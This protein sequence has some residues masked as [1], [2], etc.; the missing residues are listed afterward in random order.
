MKVALPAH[1]VA[2]MDA[3][4]D[5]VRY[6][7]RSEFVTDAVAN[8]ISELE[9]GIDERLKA[10]A[11]DQLRAPFAVA[12]KEQDHE[13]DYSKFHHA[14]LGTEPAAL[15]NLLKAATRSPG[16]AVLSDRAAAGG[17][18]SAVS[19]AIEAPA[20]D[21]PLA[22]ELYPQ[23]A[24]PT[25]GMHNRDWPTLWAASELGRASFGGAV[26]FKP[27]VESL[28]ER[29][30]ELAA[31][32]DPREFD[33]SGLPSNR[34]K[35]ERS[36]GRFQSFFVGDAPGNGPLFDLRLAAPAGTDSVLLTPPG[37]QLL[38]DLAGLEPRR[39]GVVRPEWRHAFLTHLAAWVPAD[40]G[41]LSE[42]V[43]H[44][45]AGKTTRIDLL[46][47]VD[48]AHPDWTKDPKKKSFVSTN[49]AGF[50]ARGREWN[51]IE[52]QQKDRK[53]ELVPDA[54]HALVEARAAARQVR[55]QFT[56]RTSK[57]TP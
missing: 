54:L 47:A 35:G 22:P 27:W 6:G 29:A 7:D 53:Y 9:V 36:A 19:A 14:E 26:R 39:H 46:E 1:L 10:A 23:A 48:V 4:I 57:I 45:R 17:T 20:P 43:E 32:L 8:L 16:R 40:F 37:A 52:P 44:I 28:V 13:Y 55:R 34:A 31:T 25:W 50:I 30:W 12:A 5:R 15:M 11:G 56:L 38:R 42:I 51:V 18:R 21:V 49:V 33:T 24:Q 3:T 2:A 41:F